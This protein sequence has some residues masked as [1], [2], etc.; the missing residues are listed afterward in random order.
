[1]SPARICRD[2][3]SSASRRERWRPCSPKSRERRLRGRYC[4]AVTCA[5]EALAPMTLA[6]LHKHPGGCH[7]GNIRI[8][9]E[10]PTAPEATALR[11][12]GCAFCRAHGVRTV[13]DPSGVLKVW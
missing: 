13:A 3:T 4:E 5:V 9:V 8:V 12:C 6:A 10:L 1:M 2:L 11:A 7:C